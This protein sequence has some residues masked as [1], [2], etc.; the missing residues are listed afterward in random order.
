MQIIVPWKCLYNLSNS[1]LVFVLF[2]QIILKEREGKK[3][4]ANVEQGSTGQEEHGDE[5][6]HF[7][8]DLA[9]EPA[10]QEGENR[11]TIQRSKSLSCTHVHLFYDTVSNCELLVC[12]GCC[13]KWSEYAQ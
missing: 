9:R 5:E 4:K 10:S 11:N 12:H 8:D 6:L 13:R 1:H 3:G 2:S 7:T